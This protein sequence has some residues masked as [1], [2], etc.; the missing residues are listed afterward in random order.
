MMNLMHNN[1]LIFFGVLAVLA[2]G[3]QTPFITPLKLLI[4]F[5]HELSHAIAT[6]LTGGKVLEFVVSAR[7]SGHVQSLGGSRFIIL[8]SGY[9][10]SLAFGILFYWFSKRTRILNLLLLPLALLI[11]LIAFLFS[12]SLYTSLF[13][14]GLASCLVLLIIYGTASIKRIVAII[15]SAASIIYVPLDILFDTVIFNYQRSDASM[16]ADEFGGFTWLWGMIW[17]FISLYVIYSVF[18]TK[19]KQR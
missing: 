12:A 9:L 18:F 14:L 5:F 10:G 17:I 11:L 2:L 4:V 1:K 15:F 8:S 3:W 19:S 7:Q 16:L 6:W 13:S